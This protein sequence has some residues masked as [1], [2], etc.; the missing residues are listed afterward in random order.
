MQMKKAILSPEVQ[1]K[2]ELSRQQI[3]DAR[4]KGKWA[5]F[6]TYLRLSGPGW[7]QSAMTLGGGSL[8]GSLYL[9]VLGGFSLL[10]LQPMAVLIGV[11][12]LCAIS[13]VTLAS[14]QRPFDAMRDYISPILAWAWAIASLVANMV[15]AMPQYALANGV[16]QQNLLPGVFGAESSLGE[17]GGKVVVTALIFSF[18]TI[19]TMFY[20]RDN[21][22][23]RLYEWAMKIMVFGITICFIGVVIRLALL[24]DGLDWGAI[25]WGFIPDFTQFWSPDSK[26]LPLLEGIT[27]ENVR[28]FWAEAIVNKQ[29]DV[30][31]AATATAVGINMTFLMPYSLLARGWDKDFYGLSVFDLISGMK[32]PF[33]LAT[34][35]VIIAS[36]SQF[37]MQAPAGLLDEQ[38]EVIGDE[39]HIKWGQFQGL[40]EDRTNM[41]S[42][43]T[44][45]ITP[46]DR[47]LAAMLVK[48]DAGDLAQSLKPLTGSTIANLV[49]GFGVL[50]MT[51]SS[52]TLM[53]LISGF[54]VVEVFNLQRGGWEQK[55]ASLL[56]ATGVLGP[57]LWSESLFWLA[58]PT[59]VFNYTLL[60]LAYVSFFLMMNSKNLL[61]DNMPTGGT[62][63]LVNTLL[64]V[65][66]LL[67]TIGAFYS[68]YMKA[69]MYGISAI[70]AFIVI[71]LIS[72]MIFKPKLV[73]ELKK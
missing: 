12:M 18:A 2:A 42:E 8:A 25:A 60:P 15:W 3:V 23:I 29:R 47:L 38:G 40:L 64:G 33:I 71:V 62:R 63:I 65:A 24:E 28:A 55:V 32:I 49:F 17:F 46:T 44:V 68:T 72:Q 16:V 41:I 48:R 14:G 36:A 52:I 19:I 58:V 50:G 73:Q 26:Y 30:M 57:F 37:N 61:G 4:A 70:I 67:T 20:G 56:A 9:G 39:S 35:C 6:G 5:L 54:V 11:I 51:I 69:G 43:D 13:Y 10:W 27:D 34:G 22:G 66:T 45:P 7:M 53:M 59:S 1:E 21:W 31:I